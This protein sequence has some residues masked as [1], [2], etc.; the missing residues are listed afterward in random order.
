MQEAWERLH[1]LNG[2]AVGEGGLVMGTYLHGIFNNQNLKDAF[3]N[4][5]YKRKNLAR[6]SALAGDGYDEL[7]RATESYLDMEKIWD[8]IGLESERS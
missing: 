4:Y 2:K 8:M 5:L 7:A 6:R 3:L 1:L